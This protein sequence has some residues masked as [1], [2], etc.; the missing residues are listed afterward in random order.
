VKGVQGVNIKAYHRINELRK[1]LNVD[2]YFILTEIL[3]TG[4]NAE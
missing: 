3:I 1:N 2:F 4:W